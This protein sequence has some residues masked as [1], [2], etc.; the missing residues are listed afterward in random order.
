VLVRA[1]DEPCPPAGT[2]QPEMTL[3][4]ACGTSC[5]DISTFSEVI[6]PSCRC[7]TSSLFIARSSFTHTQSWRRGSIGSEDSIVAAAPTV[8]HAG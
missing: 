6:L 4:Y 1:K 3:P 7:W 8:Q 5:A 2:E